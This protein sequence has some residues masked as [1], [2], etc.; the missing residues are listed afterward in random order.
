PSGYYLND[1]WVSLACR[2]RPF[3]APQDLATCMRRKRLY[4]FGDSTIRQWFEHISTH[5]P[6]MQLIDIGSTH[7]GPLISANVAAA[8][9]FVMY[10]THGPPF[11]TAKRPFAALHYAANE[12]DGLAGG[13]D[14][15]VGISLWAH[16]TGFPVSFYVTRMRGIC[17]A[18]VRLLKR[19][20]GTLVVFKSANTSY[21]SVYQSDWLS[22]QLD[23]VM[24][25]LMAGVV[26]ILDAWEMTAAHRFPDNLH[27][28]PVIIH[29]EIKLLLAFVCPQEG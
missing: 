14:T 15:V 13:K 18:V 25:R 12:L 20:P 1:E 19:A 21:H 22:L 17:A 7:L 9:T 27:P 5:V 16:F 8:K 23:L 11:L 28:D 4:L 2:A 29:N 24:R 3:P 26:V 6:D 10:R